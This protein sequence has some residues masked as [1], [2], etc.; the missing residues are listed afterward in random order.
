MAPAKLFRVLICIV[1]TATA[2]LAEPNYAL[3]TPGADKDLHNALRA[4]SLVLATQGQDTDP[5]ELLAAAQ[6]D[7]ARL[8]GALYANARYGGVVSILFDG[9]EVSSIPP[10]SPPQDVRRVRVRVDPGP[11]YLFAET[12]VRPLVPGTELP[13][14]FRRGQ[15]AE[16]GIIREAATASVDAWRGAGHAKAEVTEQRIVARHAEDR[17]SATLTLTPG[18]RLRFGTISVSGNEDVRSRRIRTISGLEEGRQY[19]PVEIDRAV[20]RLRRTGSFASVTV[21]ETDTI[22][23]NDTLPL[24]IEVVEQ[25]PRRFGFGAEYSTI[26]GVRL[27][28]FWLHRNFL[29]G[30]ERFRVDGAIAGLG[31]ETG[32]VDY[33]FGMRYGRP[34]TPR[35]D[36]DLFAELSFELLDEPDFTSNTTEFTLGFT[37]YATDELVVTFGLGYLY[38]DVEDDFGRETFN[39]LTLPLG[40]ELDRRNN[41]LNPTDGYYIDLEVTPFLGL[42]GTRSGGQLKLDARGYQHVTDSTTVAARVQFGSLWGPSLTDS[43]PFYRFY[44]GGGGTVRGQDYQSLGVDVGTDRTGGRSFL[45]LSGEVRAS[46]TDNIEAVG[47]IDWGYIGAEEFPDFTGDSHAGAGLG[48]RYNTGIGPIRL[49]LATPITGPSDSAGVYIYVGIGQAF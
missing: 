36:V 48:I 19:D 31:G 45:G 7:Y 27:S 23:P 9:R 20:R 6:A 29:G 24:D 37:R 15:P 28:G 39:L 2:G 25:T 13:E 18:P 44:S 35:A 5:Q 3:E 26:E 47:F 10:L 49:D 17:L 30:A 34:A 11:L 38:S 8:L 41:V 33:N 32:G 22:G 14:G 40:A 21:S 4:S 12:Q 16:T 43:P 1:L 42:T 46:V